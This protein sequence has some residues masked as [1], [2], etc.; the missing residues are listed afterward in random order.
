MDCCTIRLVK[1]NNYNS[2]MNGVQQRNC[3]VKV[4]VRGQNSCTD[5]LSSRK[6]RIVIVAR[7]AHSIK[8]HGLMSALVYQD[9]SRPWK[10]RPRE[11]S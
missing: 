9:C 1:G 7:I 5:A 8:T 10:V 3:M 11:T 6:Y 4:A 2:G